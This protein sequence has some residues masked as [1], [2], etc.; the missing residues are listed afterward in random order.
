MR[1]GARW[2]LRCY[3]PSWQE[4]YGTELAEVTG[5]GRGVTLD[6]LVGALRAWMRPVGPRTLAARRQSAVG[7]VHISWC[8]A[9]VAAAVFTKAVADP[10]L[11]GLTSG[12]AQPLW[13]VVR[14]AFVLGWLVLLLGGAGLLLR[15]AVPAVRA[16]RWHVLRPLLPGAALLLVVAAGV[17]VVGSY[18]NQAPSLRPVLAILVWLALGLALVV[19]GA[20][21]PVLTLRRS[22]LPASALRWPFRLA[23]AVGL[24]AV[25]LAAAALGQAAA[26][27]RHA[28]AWDLFLMWSAVLVLVGAAI[29][30]T[31]SLR[32]A[33]PAAGVAAS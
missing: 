19:T 14:A 1:R 26:L 12:V 18:G 24:A 25:V 2:A 23:A 4:R 11:P 29:A 9:F 10:P 28:D 15:V 21:G 3:P 8:A 17:P 20:L 31:V 5:D 33:R 16:R 32:H 27:S 30:S 22:G 6:L 7:T 13:A